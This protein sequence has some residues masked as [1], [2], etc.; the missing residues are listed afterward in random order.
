MSLL[1]ALFS[2]YPT[3][4]PTFLTVCG[5][6]GCGKRRAGSE[7]GHLVLLG[8][9]VWEREKGCRSGVYVVVAVLVCLVMAGV[10]EHD[11][12]LQR[13]C[14]VHSSQTRQ[15]TASSVFEVVLEM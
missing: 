4:P 13:Y 10:N 2:V 11:N 14:H 5:V 3:P 8:F 15:D 9:W 1:H 6:T 7:E 12:T